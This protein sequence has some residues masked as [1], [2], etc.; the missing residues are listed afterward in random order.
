MR[1]ERYDFEQDNTE[2]TLISP[3]AVLTQAQLTLKF[4]AW[5]GICLRAPRQ[6]GAARGL[7]S[8]SVIADSTLAI[9][10][11]AR[12]RFVQP[13]ATCEDSL[14][15]PT[16]SALPTLSFGSQRLVLE[17]VVKLARLVRADGGGGG[18]G[19]KRCSHR[20]RHSRPS[21]HNRTRP[22]GAHCTDRGRIRE[23]L[24]AHQRL[25]HLGPWE[26]RAVL[27]LITEIR[28]RRIGPAEPLQ[29][30]CCEMSSHGTCGSLQVLGLDILVGCKEEH[31]LLLAPNQ[32]IPWPSRISAPFAKPRQEM[33]WTDLGAA[34]Q[35]AG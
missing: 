30:A 25:Q 9:I 12:H 14:S 29:R 10:R 27:P 11:K 17:E 3:N 18:G 7:F 23:E 6:A 33:N 24:E 35:M 20:N 19:L 34:E 31:D 16:N 21:P 2:Q 26:T 15:R 13:N 5:L 1:S 4:P 28:C 22:I 8:H 32:K